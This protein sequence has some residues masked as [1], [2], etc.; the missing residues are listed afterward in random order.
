MARARWWQL[1]N[2]L[3]QQIR[4]APWRT[5]A[6]AAL[7]LLIWFALYLLLDYVL[8]RVR[9]MGLIGVVAHEY[10][11]AHFFIVLAVMLAFSN[12]ILSFGAL[13]G[14][15]E[16]AHLLCMPADAREIVTLKWVE[17]VL[18]SSWSFVL[19]GVPLMF[20]VASNADVHW[21][22]YPLFLAHFMG[23]V[24][25][26]AC[27]GALG[28]W[29]VAMY[30]PRRP[31]TAAIG[32]GAVL[33]L[34]LVYWVVHVLGDQPDSDQWFRTLM[35]H[36]GAARQPLMPS[37][38]SARGIITAMEERVG[39]SVF[40]L[41]VVLANGFF[42]AW[43][44]INVLARSWPEAFSRAQHGRIRTRIRSGWITAAVCNG[45][46]FYLPHRLRQ[47]MLKDVRA[48][49][50]DARQWSQMLI[51]F[52]LLVIY[53]LN[54]KRLPI[55]SDY[56]FMQGLIAFLNL[57][58]V[59]LILAT[60][61]SR[62]VYPLLSLESQQLW[63]IELLP[64]PR[65]T[66]LLVKFLFAMTVTTIAAVGV[67][68]IAVAMLALPPVWV[69]VHLLVCLGVCAGL[70]GLSIGLGARFPVL[71]QRNPARIASGFGGTF[72]LVASMVFV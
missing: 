61:T 64:V 1:R 8:G 35:T 72:N 9:T 63:L 14:R 57:T 45:L 70:S 5:L 67:M 42:L 53:A 11:F 50:R 4:E 29:A 30:A 69:A 33:L 54:L 23:F 31:I 24:T 39:A 13:Y 3:D 34:S 28:A 44:T 21:Y 2:L 15:D 56:P 47:V 7:L 65:S 22:Y 62:F 18:L 51:M 36:V 32:I 48:F 6:T 27:L 40:Y 20:A 43:L 60:F 52:G 59:S 49:A 71:T 17:G 55:D 12:G 16:A 68:A 58:T 66:L 10:L 46:F 25:I 19:L 37:T 26:P 41:L 38:W